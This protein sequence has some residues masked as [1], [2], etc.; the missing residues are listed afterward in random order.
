MVGAG[1]IVF[2]KRFMVSHKNASLLLR[3][4]HIG[5]FHNRLLVTAK[6]GWLLEIVAYL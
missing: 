2:F 1:L 3:E 5:F 4:K 6:T